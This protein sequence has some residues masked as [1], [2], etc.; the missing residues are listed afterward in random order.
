ME[1]GGDKQSLQKLFKEVIDKI[2]GAIYAQKNKLSPSTP[3]LMNN[4]A[5]QFYVLLNV[6]S[7]H[8]LQKLAEFKAN[9]ECGFCRF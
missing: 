5:N 7:I 8:S 4:P 2:K 9:K 6:N 1:I 3:D